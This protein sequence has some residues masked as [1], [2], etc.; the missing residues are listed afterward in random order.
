VREAAALRGIKIGPHA[1][2]L[3]DEATKGIQEFRSWFRDWLPE[4]KKEAHA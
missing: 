4:L 2:P 1:I 3:S